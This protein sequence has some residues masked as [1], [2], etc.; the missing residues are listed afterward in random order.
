MICIT[1]IDFTG[2][3]LLFAHLQNRG[4][5]LL[6]SATGRLMRQYR[7]PFILVVTCDRAE[8]ISMESAGCE[9]L[10]RALSLNPAAVSRYRYSLCG[11]DAVRHIL[12]LS[13]GVI[14]PLFGEDTI[15]GQLALAGDVARLS[16]TS[17][18]QL[19]KLVNLAV[20]FSKRIH[21]GIR[22]RV[23][24]RS[25]ADEL[26]R[27]LADRRRILVTG[28]GEGARVVI[29]SLL[30]DRHEVHVALRDETKTFLAPA[31]TLPVSYERKMEEAAWADAIVSVSS[32]LYH[33]FS[34]EECLSLAPKPMYDLA[35]PA[36]LPDSP[37]VIRKDS[38]GV[39]EPEK[40][41]VAAYVRAEAE[42]VLAEYRDWL[43]R[44]GARLAD[45]GRSDELSYE[46]MRRLSAT[47]SRLRLDG[48]TEQ[49]LRAS[50]LDSVKKAY[51]TKSYSWRSG[52]GPSGD[53]T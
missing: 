11:D 6:S 28:S 3:P 48:E 1:G 47:L 32:G 13:A 46:V 25:I 5:E 24:D 29:S 22:V 45:E 9:I 43:E 17:C 53:T 49:R 2:Q 4:R 21:S 31:G 51:M 14:S 7:F 18:P 40:E 34:L 36:D 12:L 27:R 30:R 26:A 19:N 39:D 16:G 38:L 23:F 8:A 37:N 20:S 41:R 33:T 42:K 52:S 35:S 44:S 15:Q 50:I 10:E